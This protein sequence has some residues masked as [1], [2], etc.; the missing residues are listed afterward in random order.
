VITADLDHRGVHVIGLVSAS[1]PVPSLPDISLERWARLVPLSLLITIV[2]MVQTAATTR[3]FLSDP[4]QPADVNH[5]FLGVGAGSVLAGLFGAF[6]VNASPPRTGIVAETGGRSQVAGLFAAGLVLALLAFGAALLRHV[7]E[8][9][10][11]GVLLF[12]ALR[13]IRFRQIVSI[14]Q[15]SFGEFMLIV[16]TAAAIIVLPIE[17]GVGLGIMLSLLHGIWSITQTR[18]VQFDRVPG[19]TIWWPAS[20]TMPGEGVPDVTVVA[21]Q[22]PLTFLNAATF[23]SDVRHLLKTSHPPPKLL[24]LEAS[25]IPEIDFTAAQTLRDL[26]KACDVADVTVAVARL[27]SLRAQ[28]AFERFGIHDVLPRDRIFH[29]VDEAVRALAGRS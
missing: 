22:A 19:T 13:I 16:A 5:D 14:Y 8:A 6:P 1:L 11:G 3:S 18:L 17:Q 20:P 15:A 12:V 21:F 10:L 24:V 23:R 29:S 7:P 25:G 27:E 9:A 28:D 26:I 4:D 2:V